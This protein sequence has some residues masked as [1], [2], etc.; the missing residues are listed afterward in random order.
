MQNNVQYGAPNKN[1][2]IIGVLCRSTARMMILDGKVFQT[3]NFGDRMSNRDQYRFFRYLVFVSRIFW[4]CTSF[5]GARHFINSEGSCDRSRIDFERETPGEINRSV[6]RGAQY[7]L[8][9]FRGVNRGG[10]DFSHRKIV[11][12]W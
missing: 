6:Q 12:V 1:N 4:P 11:G 10:V 8:E 9:P 3:P 7:P 2:K 5:G